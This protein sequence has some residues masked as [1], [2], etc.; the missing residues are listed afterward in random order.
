MSRYNTLKKIPAQSPF[1]MNKKR[2]IEKKRLVLLDAHAIIHRAYHALPDFASSKGEPTGALYGISTMLLK[3]VTDLKPDFIA[4]C[5]DVPEPTYRHEA[6]QAYKAGRKKADDDLVAQLIRSKD[7]FKAFHVPMYE[8]IGFEAD[9]ILGTIVEKLRNDPVEIIVASGDMDTLQLVEQGRVSVYTLKKGINDTILYDEKAVKERFGFGPELLPDYKG[10]RGDPSDNIVGIPGIGEKTASTLIQNFGTI[11]EMYRS[12][13]KKPH[14][15]TEVGIKERVVDLL[16]KHK[17]EA[18]FSKMLATIRRDAPIE[19]SLPAKKWREEVDISAIE[20]FF[21][22]LEFRSLV[23]RA[24]NVLLGE[25][26]AEKASVPKE[27]NEVVDPDELAETALAL[28]VADSSIANPSLEEVLLFAKTKSF[29]KAKEVIFSE[30][31]KR[32]LEKVF[33][34]IEKPLLPIVRK[35]GERGIAIDLSYLKALSA[36]YHESLASIER[37]IHGLAGEVFNINSPRQ[38]SV[39]LFEKLNLSLKNHKK[40]EGGVKSTRESELEKMK[41]LHP[42][43]ERILAHRE[44]QKLLSTYIDTIPTLVGEDG[45]LHARFLQAGAATGRMA[46]ENPNVQ[47]IPIKSELGRRIRRAF[48]AAPGHLLAAFDYSQIELRVA[49]FL[50]KDPKLIEIFREGGD[51]HTAVAAQVF[52]VP[53]EKVDK[54]M[55]RRAKI[56]NFGIL[57]GMGVNAL[58]GNLGTTRAEAQQFYNEYF[59]TFSVLASYLDKVKAEAERRGYTETYFG[60]RRYFSGIKSPIPYIKASSERMAINAPI[61]GTQADIIKI[62]MAKIDSELSK[63]G[64]KEKV[65]LILQVHDELVYEIENENLSEAAPFIQSIMEGVLPPESIEGISLTV[66]FSSGRDWGSLT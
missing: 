66:G 37:D 63:R 65:H 57:Y 24:R 58:K 64:L 14:L 52:K 44:L 39:I 8:K 10:L 2:T 38:L 60:R 30:L 55:R 61:Q 47:N 31:K 16:T 59:E 5:Y 1:H 45:R 29:P 40:T 3:I 32:N 22:E 27:E 9:D 25:G 20:A 6:Y 43:V 33:F 41:E 35:M 15:F 46:S 42:I 51:I 11:E 26:G 50:S 28:W 19:F 7:I 13:E 12:L 4:A 62:A 53:R 36:E 21:G 17:E 49:A 18:E 48:I 54:E 34:D 23:Q 56:I